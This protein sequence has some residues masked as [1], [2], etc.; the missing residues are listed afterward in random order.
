MRESIL[1]QLRSIL[2]LCAAVSAGWFSPGL[3]ESLRAE[4]QASEVINF[5][6]QI[7]PILAAHCYEC[8]GPDEGERQAGLRLDTQE[9]AFAP[10][11]SD[12]F[13]IVPGDV[14]QSK[15]IEVITSDD[16]DLRMPPADANDPLSNEQIEL[17]EHWISQGAPWKKH[18]AFEPPVEQIVPQVENTEWATNDLDHF[19]LARLEQEGITPRQ[20]P[21][22]ER[23]FAEPHSI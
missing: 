13:A 3:H 16:P 2:V 4:E 6:T 5:D 8:H 19:I 12:G 18:W 9:G 15:L 22:N 17:L 1:N 10:L 11:E 21:I 20:P 14:S 7:G 23:S